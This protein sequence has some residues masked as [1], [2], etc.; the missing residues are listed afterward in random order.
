MA[1]ISCSI[2]FHADENVCLMPRE[3]QFPSPA[4]SLSIACKP[5]QRQGKC[6]FW[7]ATNFIC[8]LCTQLRNLH[9][10]KRSLC[11]C[12]RSLRMKQSEAKKCEFSMR[13]I[14]ILQAVKHIETR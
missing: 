11:L 12:I 5:A 8:S 6:R 2:V 3:R 9:T 4:K 14:R 7:T 1:N 10:Q 13:K